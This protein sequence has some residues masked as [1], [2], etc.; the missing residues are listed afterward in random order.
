MRVALL[1]ILA[2]IACGA[3]QPTVPSQSARAQ[4]EAPAIMNGRLSAGPRPRLGCFAWSPAE[5]AAACITGG[6]SGSEPVYLAFVDGHT[7]ATILP[8]TIDAAAVTAANDTLARR[9]FEPLIVAPQTFAIGTS[10]DVSAARLSFTTRP[11]AQG[12]RHTMFQIAADCRN[13]HSNVIAFDLESGH[14]RASIRPFDD[15]AVVEVTIH[16]VHAGAS[17][18]SFDAVVFDAKQCQ[19]L[20][21]LPPDL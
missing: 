11:L 1:M 4:Q 13:D 2:S 5:P 6:G 7:T 18:D 9:G 16:S 8:S 12:D 3:A 10:I 19:T 17:S 14:A 20:S 21:S 15:R